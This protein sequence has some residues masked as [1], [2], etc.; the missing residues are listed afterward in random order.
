MLDSYGL[1][2]DNYW[3]YLKAHIDYTAKGDQKYMVNFRSIA[4][5]AEKY[6]SA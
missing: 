3:K 2:I 1:T 6:L 4:K 5:E